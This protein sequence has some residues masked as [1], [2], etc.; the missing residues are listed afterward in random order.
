MGV[1]CERSEP[2]VYTLTGLAKNR[3]P[4]LGHLLGNGT[5]SQMAVAR[6][7]QT[8]NIW[9]S[10]LATIACE[11]TVQNTLYKSLNNRV[12]RWLHRPCAH[13]SGSRDGRVSGAG[14]GRSASASPPA[15]GIDAEEA[16]TGQLTERSR[17]AAI[18]VIRQGR[19]LGK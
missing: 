6:L 15:P 17:R 19:Y 4:V 14:G 16:T 9:I 1:R 18:V 2:Y 7:L 8:C 13:Q 5:P 10:D 12:P 11:V 3:G